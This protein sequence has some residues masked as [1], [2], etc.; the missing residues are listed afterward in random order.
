MLY[1][2]LII[3][4]KELCF[5]VISPWFKYARQMLKQSG[6][7]VNQKPVLIVAKFWQEESQV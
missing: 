2:Q 5:L 7:V 3:T 1:T 4:D 6:V